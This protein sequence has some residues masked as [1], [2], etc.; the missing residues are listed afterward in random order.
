MIRLILIVLLFLVSLLA[1]FR[2]PAYYLWIAAILVTGYPLIFSGAALLL[3][4]SGFW[5]KAY[6]TFGTVLGIITFILCLSPIARAYFVGADLKKEMSSIFNA[7]HKTIYPPQQPF[8]FL[9]LFSAA[10]GTQSNDITYVKYADTSLKLDYYR[11]GIPGKRPCV[12]MI[13]GG[14]WG[15]G[16]SKELPELNPVLV[17]S[18]YNV[19][20][21]NYRLAPK[22]QS[23][24][25]VEDVK[26]CLKYLRE[27]ADNLNI[28]TTKFILIGRSAG[29][30]IALAA[31]YTINDPSIIGVVDFYGPADMVWGYSI[32]SNPLIMDSRKVM[33][34]YLG[35]SYKEVPQH[36]FNSSPVEFVKK[37]SPATLI[38]H[39]GTDVLVSPIH[40]DKLL[41]KLK[42]ARVPAFYLYL[43]WGTHGFD[44]SLNGPGGQL[45]TYAV[46]TFI[47]TITQP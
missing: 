8:S 6:Q 16:N 13:H 17:K 3:T 47:N 33:G 11:A 23:P 38:I 32:P 45:S 37:T 9:K 28:D 25:P 19:A 22:Y 5:I 1:V 2:A 44:Y 27:H 4:V 46:Q 40:S 39:G 10:N 15:G 30:Q 20:A 14:S 35:G 7:P 43:P 12:V 21:I 34:N 42:K 24:A 31:A 36:Y 26:N 29:A 41:A 18:G